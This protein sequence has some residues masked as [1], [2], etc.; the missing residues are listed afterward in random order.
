MTDKYIKEYYERYDEDGRLDRRY[1]RLEFLTT[2]RYIEKYLEEGLRV[3]EVGAGT[4]RYSLTLS[5]MGYQVDS[6]ELVEHNINIYKSKIKESDNVN[7]Q[8]GTALDLSRF[9]ENTF[10][11]TLVLGPMY[12]VYNEEDKK[13]VIEEAKRVTKKDGYII[14]AY[15]THDAVIVNWGL[16]GGKLLEGKEKSMFTEDFKCISTPQELFAM[17]HI[18]EFNELIEPFNITHLHTVGTD[19][20]AP[21]F[22]DIF[23]EMSDE[24]FDYWKEY[25]FTTCEKKDL[26]GYSSHIIYVGKK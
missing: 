22:S 14:I 20:V 5:G 1:N 7:V 10:D 23:E 13:K 12:H 4:G 2:M 8:Q 6:I 17:F 11:M 9:E 24:M 21:L 15:I 18:D 16:V 25:H 3:L 26:I 19:G